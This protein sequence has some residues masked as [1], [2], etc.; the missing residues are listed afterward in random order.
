MLDRLLDHL[1]QRFNKSG[2]RPQIHSGGVPAGAAAGTQ[3]R[4][5]VELDS[6]ERQRPGRGTAHLS[7]ATVTVSQD[8]ETLAHSAQAGPFSLIWAYSRAREA[9]EYAELGQDYLTFSL[10]DRE[11]CLVLCD[12]VSQSFYGELAA[13]ILG[14][15]VLDWLQRPTHDRE[16][17]PTVDSIAED[18]TDMLHRLTVAA[19][20]TVER[21]PLPADAIPLLQEIL[22]AK[23][24]SGSDAMCVAARVR[25][26]DPRT[27]TYELLTVEL[28]DARLRLWRRGAEQYR[29]VISTDATDRRWSSRRGLVGG[30]PLVRL[31]NM[32][33]ADGNTVTLVV[34]SDGLVALD[35]ASGPPDAQEIDHI[36][37]AARQRP[38][39]DD[40]AI[41]R[42]DLRSEVT[43]VTE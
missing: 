11:C 33:L 6:G 36:I 39:S 42:L 21:H 23:R 19:T 1:R 7:T 18:L 16:L 32:T 30:R 27:D 12:G 38:N 29:S 2:Q 37:Q 35:E 10:D 9:I 20:E 5:G 14:D 13:Q 17:T 25:L 4:S 15:A 22:E 26:R 3:T 24:R 40:I 34:Y 43:S 31:D 28:G 41:L 8:E